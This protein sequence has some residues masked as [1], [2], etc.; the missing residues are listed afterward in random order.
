MQVWGI[1]GTKDM[2]ILQPIALCRSRELTE[3]TTF[4]SAYSAM[5]F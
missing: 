4:L 2:S 1:H 5:Q 3:Q